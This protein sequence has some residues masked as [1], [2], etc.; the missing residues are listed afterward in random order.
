MKPV[1]RSEIHDFVLIQTII[2]NIVYLIHE[3]IS[4]VD[5][6]PVQCTAVCDICHQAVSQYGRM[7]A[8]CRVRSDTNYISLLQHVTRWKDVLTITL[9]Y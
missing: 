1:C 6:W 8:C 2:L 7:G 3:F 5:S 9:N 4:C